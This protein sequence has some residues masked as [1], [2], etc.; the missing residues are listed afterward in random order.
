MERP[1]MVS[2]LLPLLPKHSVVRLLSVADDG[3]GSNSRSEFFDLVAW[4]SWSIVLD[5]YSYNTIINLVIHS[6]QL[7]LENQYEMV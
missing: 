6:A 1:I 4:T 2:F 3:K 7:Y 5:I